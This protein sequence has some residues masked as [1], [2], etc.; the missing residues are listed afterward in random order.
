MRCVVTDNH[1]TNVKA[2]KNLV[3]K[4]PAEGQFCLQH[5][6]NQTKTYLFFDNVHL[7]KNV[8]NNL[9]RAKK[10]VFP[11]ISFNIQ[12]QIIQSD[13]GYITWGDLHSIHDK[14]KKLNGNLKMAPKL[15]YKALHPGNNSKSNRYVNFSYSGKYMVDNSQL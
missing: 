6:K 3:K 7:V 10:F 1:A 11:S 4:Y 13:A 5:P 9:L 14:D 8:R 12:N 15:T 2:F